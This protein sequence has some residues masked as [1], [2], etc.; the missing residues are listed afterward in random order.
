MAQMKHLI[1]NG[2]VETYAPLVDVKGSYTAQFDMYALSLSLSPSLTICSRRFSS[3]VA[4]KKSSAVVTTINR[5]WPSQRSD[6]CWSILEVVETFLVPRFH[7]RNLILFV[8]PFVRS[9]CGVTPA[10]RFLH[11]GISSPFVHVPSGLE[12]WHA[13]MFTRQP[14]HTFR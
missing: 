7:A 3:T 4:G 8:R 14:T 6:L 5:L 13:A 11:S 2:I 10:T 9:F 1:E 12:R